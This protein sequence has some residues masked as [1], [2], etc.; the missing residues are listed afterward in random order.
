LRRQLEAVA[1]LKLNSAELHQYKTSLSPV[2]TAVVIRCP[3]ILIHLNKPFSTSGSRLKGK[4]KRN[5]GSG[6][7]DIG[8]GNSGR[9]K[10]G[11]TILCPCCGHPCS[12]T[13]IFMCRLRSA[14]ILLQSILT[15]LLDLRDSFFFVFGSDVVQL[16][17]NCQNFVIGHRYKKLLN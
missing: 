6:R 5:D 17:T 14:V 1:T 3:L 2:N 8:D 12:K 16:S 7:S 9:E 10:G 15:A 13:E 11:S 4:V